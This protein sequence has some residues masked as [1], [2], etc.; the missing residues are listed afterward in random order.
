MKKV[1][2]ISALA[3]AAAV[4]C[5]KSDIVDTKFNEQISFETYLGRDAQTKAEVINN[6]NLGK[7]AVY[8]YYTGN[9]GWNEN[10]TTNLWGDVIQIDKTGAIVVPENADPKYWANTNDLYSFFAY[11]PVDATKVGTPVVKDPTIDF[12]VQPQ[13][14]N[15]VDLLYADPLMDKKPG[16]FADGK[17]ALTMKH[18][19]SRITVKAKATS[20][21]F[22][23]DVKEISLAGNFNVTGK[24]P[25]STGEW[26]DAAPSTA[27]NGKSTFEIF[28][29]NKVVADGKTTYGAYNSTNA[30]KD[31][32]KDY[33]ETT[34]GINN[35][36][37]IIPTVP[38]EGAT[39]ADAILTVYYTTYYAGQESVVMSKDIAVPMN[40]EKG[41]AYS[42]NLNFQH[43]EV[44]ITFSVDVEEWKPTEKDENGN[45]VTKE[46]DQNQDI[47]A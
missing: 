9:T 39:L 43:D 34:D 44:E 25:L 10:S 15:Q 26:E 35:Y 40:F 33:A 4:S 37:M 3:I 11:A 47:K 7:V 42:I 8:A 30:L 31:G 23:F 41:M 46:K 27:N 28:A 45:D 22:M 14:P 17:V 13:V 6:A 2:F 36:L 18:A 24:L 16:F 20:E 21:E 29:N 5:T 38:A 12:T 1:I 32:Y 19:L